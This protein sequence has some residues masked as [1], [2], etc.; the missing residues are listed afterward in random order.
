L[1]VVYGLPTSFGF[2]FLRPDIITGVPL[3][4]TDTDAPGGRRINPAAFSTSTAFQNGSFER[5]SV[6]G[7]ALYQFDLSLNRAFSFTETVKVQFQVDAFNVLN[8][9][10]FEDVAG[11]DL[12]LGTLSANNVFTPN[13]TF[14]KS[15][16]LS[17]GRTGFGSFYTF[18]GPRIVRLSLKFSF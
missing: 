1:N 15:A 6:R 12:S 13:Q 16:S 3:F 14:G 4:L 9:A 7:F 18:G 8:H 10:S 2:A 17:G 11:Q 5:N